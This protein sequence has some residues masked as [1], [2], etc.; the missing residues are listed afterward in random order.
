MRT[1][2][3]LLFVAAIVSAF[4]FTS[5]NFPAQRVN[6]HINIT[7][8]AYSI[9]TAMLCGLVAFI[10]ELINAAHERNLAWRS[11]G[12][13]VCYILC[14]LAPLVIVPQILHAHVKILILSGKMQSEDLTKLLA[15]IQANLEYLSPIIVILYL[16]A[17]WVAL[18]YAQNNRTQWLLTCDVVVLCCH[19]IALLGILYKE[20]VPLFGEF[21]ESMRTGLY[22]GT[23]AVVLLLQNVAFA[24]ILIGSWP[25]MSSASTATP[26]P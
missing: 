21:P 4:A 23:I 12:A 8:L 5:E 3:S 14:T 1:L 16:M 13:F 9:Y 18:R 11:I 2:F 19:I 20:D 22:A 6:Y 26:P 10:I 25:S 15:N 7:V 17:D 24:V